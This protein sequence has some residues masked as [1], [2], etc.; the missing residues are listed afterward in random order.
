[1]VSPLYTCTR[2]KKEYNFDHIKYDDDKKLICT[3]CLEKQ[4]KII[5]EKYAAEKANAEIPVNYICAKCRFKFIIKKGSPKARKCP[6]CSSPKILVVKRY[7]DENDLID[8]SMDPK[9]DL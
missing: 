9:F 4:Q 1:M 3:E 6:Y 5:K 2:C 7:K 8:D